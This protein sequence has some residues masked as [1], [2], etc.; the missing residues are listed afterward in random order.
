M[1][2]NKNA[3]VRVD[4]L[5]PEHSPELKDQFDSFFKSLG[6]VP[7][8]VLTM[9][10]KPKLVRAFVQLQGAVWDPDSKVDRGLK[11]LI[12]HV[13]SRTV[14]DAYSM[15]HTASGALHFGL[16]EEKVAA[17]GNYRTSALFSA[18][19][20]SALD[21]AI[22]ASSV[23]NT[24][25]DDMFVELR[26]YWDEEQIIEIVATI[27]AL[28]FLNRWNTAMATPIEPEPLAV[29]RKHLAPHGWSAGIHERS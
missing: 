14:G 20:R 21:L 26:R 11:R 3:P 4:P 6:F 16:T 23:P 5:P 24:V 12:G 28:G 13:A 29:G 10:R 27:S 18:A 7:N 2:E 17:V 22:A 25:T 15:A 1:N 19:E 8:S 9:Q